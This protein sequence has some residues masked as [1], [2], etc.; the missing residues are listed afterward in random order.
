MSK[1]NSVIEHTGV[2]AEIVGNKL[3]VNITQM[4]ACAGCHA[5][6]ACTAADMSEKQIEAINTDS[7]IRIG[8]E[9]IVYGQRQLGMKAVLIAFVVPFMMLL[10]VLALLQNTSLSEPLSGTIALATLIPYYVILSFFKDKLKRQ[11]L[12]YARKKD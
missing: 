2:V 8:D 3:L 11:F 5:K 7:S 1:E 6:S 10:I 12:F 4:A 9:V